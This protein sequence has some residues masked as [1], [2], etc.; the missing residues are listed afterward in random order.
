MCT[1]LGFGPMVGGGPGVASPKSWRSGCEPATL[2]TEPFP[3]CPPGPTLA[4]LLASATR[5]AKMASLMRRFRQRSASL[6]V[7]P[8][9]SLRS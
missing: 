9:F 1:G 8:S 2:E 6:L 7:L 3:L 4:L 5:R